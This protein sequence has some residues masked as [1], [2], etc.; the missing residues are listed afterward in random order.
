MK[1]NQWYRMQATAGD[2]S[3]VDIHIIDIIGDWIDELIN[4][5][6]GMKATVTAKAFIDE[7]SK[8]D[9][10]V[11]TIRVHINSP[12][13][14][15]FAALNIANALRDQQA[16]KGRTVETIV[17]GLAASAASVILMAGSTVRMA[18]NALVMVHNPWS[19][20]IG[21]AK[22]MRKTADELDTVRNTLV[23]TYKWHSSLSDEAIV[24]LIDAE[25]WM[26]ADQALANGF[27]T[28]KIE[29]LQAAASLDARV[30]AKLT[31]PEKFKARI[32]A[33]T[34]PPV[35]APTPADAADVLTICQDAGC[36]VAFAR[37]LVAEKVTADVARARAAADKTARIAAAA[38]VTEITALCEKAK[39]PE[40]AA[41]YIAGAMTADAVRAHLTTITAKLDRVEID[42]NLD[43][44]AGSARATARI[45]HAAVYAERNRRVNKE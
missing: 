2:P 20:A 13:G 16:S 6:Y 27:V 19:V 41:G 44:N 11:T 38:R 5:Y 4:E 28:E 25:T 3:T 29:G 32:A 43:P 39:Q 36:D 9:A 24:A 26:D 35:V 22:D 34:K 45:D 17:D 18:D 14:D 30:V 12:G 31:V 42:A 10:A 15:V 7:L 40:L 33:L 1:K 8:L 37:T 21:S 23:A